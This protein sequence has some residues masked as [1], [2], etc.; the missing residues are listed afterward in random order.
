MSSEL[1]V[2]SVARAI[3][4]LEQFSLERPELNLTEIS[5]A[6]GLSKSTTHRL[7]STL[8]ATEMVEFD[9]ATCR[10]RLG[11]KAFRLGS[12]V[13]KSMELVKQA[14]PLLW[15]IAEETN[16]TAFLV[17]ADGNEALCLRRVDG[18][19]QVRVLFLEAGKHSAFNCGAAQR[20]LL[21]H[22]PDWRWE[23]VVTNHT[24]RMTQYSL[25]SRE[26][27]ERD[28]REIRERGYAVSWEDVTLH[29]CALGAPV[30]DASGSVVAAVSI[31]GIVQRFSAER[32]PTLIRRIMEVGDEISRRLG[33]LPSAGTV[34]DAAGR[35][36][37]Q[38]SSAR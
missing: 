28:R 15:G 33:Y 36:S 21:A 18:A 19:H 20:V 3:A 30:R 7:L 4:I 6:I 26:E 31:S 17:V 14:D 27:L 12:V 24:K 23:E 16:E 37:A 32:L 8:E 10:Y 1:H 29:A 9:R 34:A 38:A 22:L 5:T 35:T 13:S 25:V 2:R 11:L